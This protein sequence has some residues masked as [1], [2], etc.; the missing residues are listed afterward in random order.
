MR[1]CRSNPFGAQCSAR[2]AGSVGPRRTHFPGVYWGIFPPQH[3]SVGVSTRARGE[4]LARVLRFA[5]LSIAGVGPCQRSPG[6]RPARY[7]FSSPVF[8]PGTRNSFGSGTYGPC[9]GADPISRSFG[10]KGC[11]P[12]TPLVRSSDSF[13]PRKV[14][15]TDSLCGGFHRH[16]W[17][18]G[19][20][21]HEAWISTR[22]S[23]RPPRSVVDASPQISVAVHG[24]ILATPA[25]RARFP[26]ERG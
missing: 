24:F 1:C 4:F 25:R 6:S 3:I 19:G 26:E 18:V 9:C 12:R 13:Q 2:M 11:S 15:G 20:G 10:R 14:V 7:R 16:R 22:C 23:K 17:T 5:H 8:R 21:R